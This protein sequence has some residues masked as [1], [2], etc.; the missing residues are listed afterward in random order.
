MHRF[1]NQTYGYQRGNS[2]GEGQIGKMRLTHIHC[3]I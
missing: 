3:C 1:Q 2:G